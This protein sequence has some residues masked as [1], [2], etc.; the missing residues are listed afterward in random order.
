MQ[1]R[2][3]SRQ[4]RIGGVLVVGVTRG[5][6]DSLDPT[7]NAAFTPVE[8][9]RAICLRLYDSDAKSRVVPELASALPTISKDKL[10]YTIPLRHGLQFNDG[11]PFNAQAVVTTLERDLTLPGS[12]RASDLASIDN[13]TAS[14]PYTAVIHLKTPFTP[15]LATLAANDGIVMS[16]TQL[17]KLG[18]RFGTDPVGVGPFMFDHRVVGD[19]IT[20]IKSPYYAERTAVHLDKIV[21]KVE[22]SAADGNGGSQGRGTSR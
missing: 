12:A 2:N 6:A 21:F 15:L 1:P 10:T 3:R 19:S 14:G 4:D 9:F 5:D 7:L 11:T 18:T 8:V 17:A 20:V 22:G 13:V 16:P